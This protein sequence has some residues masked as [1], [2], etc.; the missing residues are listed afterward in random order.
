M[1]IW[2][3]LVELGQPMNMRWLIFGDFNCVK[4]PAEKQ[5]G[6]APPGT[7]SKTLLTAAFRLDFTMPQEWAATTLG[8]PIGIAIPCGASSIGCFSTMSGSRLACTVTPISAHREAF[9]I[10]HRPKSFRFFNM[11]ADHSNFIATMENGWKLSTAQYSLYR[12]L[13]PIKGPLKAFNNLHF[14]HISVR[15]KEPDL[16]L[17]DAQLQFES[18]PK[19]AAIRDSLGEHRKKVVFLAEVERHFY[20]QKA[21]IHFLKIDR[22]IKFFHD[23][24]KRNATKSSILTITKSDGPIITSAADIG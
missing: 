1:S 6:V 23:M 2:E 21:K 15:A 22:N 3:K 24:V 20:Y 14:S 12:K 10:I 7:S 4:F 9:P 5:L 18:D 11:W 8:I 17:Q 16:A 19:N 13:K